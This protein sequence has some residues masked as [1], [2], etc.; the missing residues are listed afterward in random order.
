[1]IRLSAL[2]VILGI[3]VSGAVAGTGDVAR[4]PVI[5]CTD[6]FHPHDDPDD[7]FDIASMY[8]IDEIDIKAVILDQGAKQ[9]QKP[10]RIAVEQLNSITGRK[11]PWAIGLSRKLARSFDTGIGEQPR[12]QGGVELILK[13]LE[14]SKGGVTVIAVGSLRDIAAAFNRQPELFRQKVARLLIFIGDAQGAFRE[15]N[16]ELD[17]VAYSC[18]MGSG[19]PVYW[20]PCFDG[21]A[22]KN[23]NG[24][25]SYWKA[26]HAD[27]LSGAAEPVMNFFIPARDGSLMPKGRRS[28]AVFA[29]A[30]NRRYVLR[31]GRYMT[32]PSANVKDGDKAVD[33]F[34]FQPVKVQ[35]DANGCE[36]FADSA[37]AHAVNRFHITDKQTYAEVMTS[38]T[39]ELIKGLGGQERFGK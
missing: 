29:F 7:H 28:T 2:L 12:Y 17:P 39:R 32:V 13:V 8:A 11:V 9:E 16:V 21:G 34:T 4:V 20:V 30:A 1:M 18:V 15:Y 3:A 38:C 5:Y 24:N 23:E 27:L 26:A 37:G 35:V 36:S 6:L 22:G 10:G 25:A 31:D 33:V 14:E 19:L